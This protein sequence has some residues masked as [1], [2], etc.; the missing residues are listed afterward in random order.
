MLGV[1]TQH[2]RAWCLFPPPDHDFWAYSLAPYLHCSSCVDR[3]AKHYLPPS[4]KKGAHYSPMVVPSGRVC[5]REQTCSQTICIVGSIWPCLLNGL[6]W[7]LLCTIPILYFKLITL[8]PAKASD[9]HTFAPHKCVSS[10]AYGGCISYCCS[11][12]MSRGM[13]AAYFMVM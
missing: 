4:S 2:G 8:F 1:P 9:S 7:G 11:T 10:K 5:S 6:C 13:L 3:I 12:V